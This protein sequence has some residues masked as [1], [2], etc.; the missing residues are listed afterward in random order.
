MSRAVV[1]LATLL[2][3]I[4]SALAEPIIGASYIGMCN[5][6]FPCSNGL[7]VFKQA[8][9]TDI[10]A[11]GYLAE[12]FGTECACVKR[13]LQLPGKL[14]IRVHLSNGTCFPERRRRCT[15]KDVFA[16][17]RKNEAESLVAKRDAKVLRRYRRSIMRTQ[18]IL[19][20]VLNNPDVTIRYGLCLECT[21]G[22]KARS[23]LRDV[24]LEYVKPEQI[25]DSVLSQSCLKNTICER[26][27]ENPKYLRNQKCIG[28]LDGTTMFEA[29]WSV[30]EKANRKCEAAF[31]WSTGFNILPFGYSGNFIEPH[32]R[33]ARAKSWE[34]DGVNSALYQYY[35]P[36]GDAP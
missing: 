15:N 17:L 7:A 16:G 26:H 30:F 22:L 35:S 5:P 28:D 23:V 10:K 20:P 31:Y 1:I 34:F 36:S 6:N 24:A 29:D 3:T 18:R 2:L 8:K 9:D 11:V 19:A 33:T 12:T 14:Y 27:G 21:F 32:L 13:F 4:T 25:V